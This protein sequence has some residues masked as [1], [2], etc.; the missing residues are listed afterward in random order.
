EV[1]SAGDRDER[2][3]EAGEERGRWEPE[4]SQ[5]NDEPRGRDVGQDQRG[6]HAEQAERI[7][8]DESG[9]ARI[10]ERILAEQPEARK[11]ERQRVD[12]DGGEHE[13]DEGGQAGGGHLGPE[14]TQRRER[15]GNVERF[16]GTRRWSGHARA[17]RREPGHY[18]E[19]HRKRLRLAKP[20]LSEG[21][22]AAEL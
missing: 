19:E 20:P 3:R 12:R 15:H 2:E 22:Q 10:V 13:Q 4:A 18:A 5:R 11:A 8:D 17:D 9:A 7:R 6:E 14:Q 1:V 16:A 21:E